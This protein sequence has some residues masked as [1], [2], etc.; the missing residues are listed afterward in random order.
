MGREKSQIIFGVVKEFKEKVKDEYGVEKLILF[1]SQAAGDAKMDSDIDLIV[2]SRKIKDKLTFLSE[3]YHE[4]HLNQKIDYPV[5]FLCFTLEEF[6]NKSKLVT[7]V[8]E[9]L[10]EGVMV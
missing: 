10:K 2:V 3:L 4:W 5:D 9:A 7:I 6:E 8:R 1:G